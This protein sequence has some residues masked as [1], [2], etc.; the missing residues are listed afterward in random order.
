MSRLPA[1]NWVRTQLR[2]RPYV[3]VSPRATKVPGTHEGF[4]PYLM[5]L[6]TCGYT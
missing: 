1:A 4:Q 6:W 5:V 2:G 3:L